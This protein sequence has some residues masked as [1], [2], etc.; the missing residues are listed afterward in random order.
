[1]TEPET[2]TKNVAVDS[3]VDVQAGVVHGGIHYMTSPDAS[4]EQKFRTGVRLLEADVPG[5]AWQLLHEAVTADYVTNEVYFYWLLAL[6]SGKTRNELSNEQ[7]AML[8]NREKL[9]RPTGDG[10]WAEGV[11]AI[12]RLLDFA[13]KP[14]RDLHLLLDEF[15]KLDGARRAMILKHLEMF[16]DGPLQ[17]Q[18]WDR[19]LTRAELEQTADDRVHRVWKFF[20]PDPAGPRRGEPSPAE[21]PTITRIQA[22]AGTAVFIAATVHIGYLLAQADRVSLLF[23]HLISVPIGYFGARNGM[24]W[25]FRTVRR[26]AKDTEY[27]TAQYRKTNARPDGFAR[28]V[29]NRFDHYFARYVPDGVERNAWLEETAG[30]RRRMRDEIVNL[31][32]EERTGAEKIHWLIRHRASD[33]RDR[34]QQGT[35]W[36]YR[37]ELETPLATR[38]R[39]VLGLAALACGGSWAIG[40]AALTGPLTATRST[41]LMLTGGWIAARAWLRITLE[42]RRG[43]ADEYECEQTWK[44]DKAAYDRWKEKLADR[45]ADREMAA[46]LDCDRKVLLNEVLQHY[47][48]TMSSVIAHAFIEARAGSAPRARVQGGPWRYLRYELLVFLLTADGVRQLSV[49]L[50][51]TRGTLHDR[52]R[53]NYRYE[54]VAAVRVR[55]ADDD[56]RT[57]ELGLVNGQEIKVQVMEADMEDLQEGEN[58]GDVS[59]VTL[60]AAGLHH[61]LHVLEG[62]AAEGQKWVT[63]E[64]ERARRRWS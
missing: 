54:A 58:P 39:A 14:E 16:L 49:K 17:D 4:P 59:K 55:Q 46:W 7:T 36:S 8:R 21:I 45:P 48:L 15:D 52:H 47:R 9:I 18:M 50:D 20:H 64:D 12:N 56:E 2:A 28:R 34:Q 32:R 42:E 61:T 57:F 35:L 26:R 43:S 1:M 19:A 62:I 29:S 3:H 41:A 63:R 25:R 51:F 22:L 40:E 38:A 30:I 23:V 11:K 10:E 6:V 27:R 24:E 31:Y 60:D 33:L 5:R 13:Q 37:S 44:G 53:T